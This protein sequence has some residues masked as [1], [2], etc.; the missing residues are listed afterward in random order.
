MNK[1][2]VA[3]VIINLALIT[4]TLRYAYQIHERSK[5][6][7]Q[8]RVRFNKNMDEV[9]SLRDRWLKMLD[10]PSDALN[11]D[12]AYFADLPKL[13]QE[14]IYCSDCSATPKCNPDGAGA[15]AMRTNGEWNC[16]P[17]IPSSLLRKSH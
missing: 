10:L 5:E 12:Q 11:I 2:H 6:M 13:S 16:N 17:R 14:L 4:V 9:N 8:M 1:F 15:V 7:D 3:C